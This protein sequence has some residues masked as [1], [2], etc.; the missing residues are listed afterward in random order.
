MA[1]GLRSDRVRSSCEA[2]PA[3][4][5]GY[6]LVPGVDETIDCRYI[7]MRYMLY[8]KRIGAACA[9]AVVLAT[10]PAAAAESPIDTS[11]ATRVWT[12]RQAECD[13]DG[14]RLWGISVCGPQLFVD[15]QTRAVV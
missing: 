13:R 2:V 1:G 6:I 14:G 9:I 15:P 7:G 3:A 4:A 11:A 10:F 8:C 5:G 12:Q